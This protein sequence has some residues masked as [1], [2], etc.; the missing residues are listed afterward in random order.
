MSYVVLLS[1]L[2]RLERPEQPAMM[3]AMKIV[4]PSGEHPARN[5]FANRGRGTVG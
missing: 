2:L 5:Q 4:D 3:T 1:Y